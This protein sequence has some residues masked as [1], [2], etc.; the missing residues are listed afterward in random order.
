MIV[1]GAI[2]FVLWLGAHPVLAGTLTGGELAQFLMYAV[3][4]GIVGRGA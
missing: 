2:T 3:Y 4:M 1:F